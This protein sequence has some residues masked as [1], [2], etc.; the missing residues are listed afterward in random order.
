MTPLNSLKVLLHYEKPQCLKILVFGF[1][2]LHNV[3]LLVGAADPEKGAS[4]ITVN[5]I[6]VQPLDNAF[7]DRDVHTTVLGN[8]Y[9]S[10][11]Q[12]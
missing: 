10:I 2:Q 7:M 8:V 5:N 9:V 1:L 4:R 11:A 12:L 3:N 6:P